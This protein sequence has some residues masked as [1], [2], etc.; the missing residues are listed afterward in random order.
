[1]AQYFANCNTILQLKISSGSSFHDC[2]ISCKKNACSTYIRLLC[3]NNLLKPNGCLE[4]EL[5]SKRMKNGISHL[6]FVSFLVVG[7]CYIPAP[8]RSQGIS[9]SYITTWQERLVPV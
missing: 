8:D 6:K 2:T 4:Y 5:I 3:L 9:M 7:N 1:M